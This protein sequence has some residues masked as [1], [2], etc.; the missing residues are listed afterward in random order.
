M[1]SSASAKLSTSAPLFLAKVVTGT[2]IGCK[3]VD[4]ALCA[5]NI[6]TTLH[7]DRLEFR[8][9]HKY[10][11]TVLVM[12]ELAHHIKHTELRHKTFNRH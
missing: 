6:A 1:L 10:S 2:C 8:R 4:V 5:W 12:P 9:T 3:W 7:R 11:I